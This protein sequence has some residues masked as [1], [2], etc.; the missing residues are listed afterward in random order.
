MTLDLRELGQSNESSLG[1]PSLK[2][3]NRKGRGEGWEAK[4]KSLLS[5]RERGSRVAV[6]L[7][8]RQSWLEG[9]NFQAST[10][11]STKANKKHQYWGFLGRSEPD[12]TS[13]STYDPLLPL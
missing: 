9:R 11:R 12:Y 1:N 6:S 2:G 7:G 8:A 4:H 13:E 10:G 5:A 3:V